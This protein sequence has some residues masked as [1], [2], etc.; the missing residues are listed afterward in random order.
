M[1]PV[2]DLK[3]V[4][5]QQK[6]LR[7]YLSTTG[8][9]PAYEALL[10]SLLQH[11]P[12]DGS[13]VFDYSAQY[14]ED[15]G[16]TWRASH[17]KSG[18]V[19]IPASLT[20]RKGAPA[21]RGRSAPYIRPDVAEEDDDAGRMD[22]FLKKRG[23]A[24]AGH[25]PSRGRAQSSGSS[26]G[27]WGGGGGDEDDGRAANNSSDSD[28][29]RRQPTK[30]KAVATKARVSTSASAR[31]NRNKANVMKIHGS[32]DESNNDSDGGQPNRSDSS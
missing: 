29:P 6:E 17:G 4:K 22:A 24:P 10:V 15:Y 25:G 19:S 13:D 30:Q 7:E 23:L 3:D 11:P 27:R 26:G 8:F 18:K 12:Q 32:S 14:F 20:P 28:R 2:K 9:L 21:S 16:K 1:P 5:N 31:N